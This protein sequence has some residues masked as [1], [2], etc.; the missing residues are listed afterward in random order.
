M[1]CLQGTLCL[2]NRQ[3]E[4]LLSHV[5][6]VN[7]SFGAAT[8]STLPFDQLISELERVL[9]KNG[10]MYKVFPTIPLNMAVPLTLCVCCHSCKRTSL[11]ATAYPGL[12]KHAPAGDRR[13]RRLTATPWCGKWQCK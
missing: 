10:H 8:T 9:S 11:S 7:S 5:L 6:R 3:Y 12:L 2:Q 4:H 13:T 1:L